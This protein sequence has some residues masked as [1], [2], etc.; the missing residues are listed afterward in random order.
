M[1]IATIRTPVQSRR[2]ARESK[3]RRNAAEAV[4]NYHAALRLDHLA[5]ERLVEDQTPETMW[6]HNRTQELLQWCRDELLVSI[7]A[8]S[9]HF[10]PRDTL[11]TRHENRG[12]RVGD[13]VYLAKY[14]EDEFDL[15]I[16]ETDRFGSLCMWLRIVPGRT[17]RDL[18]RIDA[19]VVDVKAGA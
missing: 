3:L 19:V 4:K 11:S 13:V 14:A 10:S 6:R 5:A 2:A 15:E 16:G 8:F 1:S 18:D 9:P 17:K 12:I 7:L